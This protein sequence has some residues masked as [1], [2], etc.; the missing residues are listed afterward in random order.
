MK[1]NFTTPPPGL[2]GPILRLPVV[3]LLVGWLVG[4]IAILGG[5]AVL[6]SALG[7]SGPEISAGLIGA[8]ISVGV[9]GLG[10]L[11]AVVGGE[12][13]ATEMPTVW[14]ASTVIRFLAAPGLGFLLYFA[15]RPATKP[16]VLGLALA[17]L[18]LLK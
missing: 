1:V 4:S 14:L 10:L 3:G 18:V 15:L 12:R 17:Y 7:A 13:P 6:S 2:G 9:M 11:A 16:Y 8:S 5:G